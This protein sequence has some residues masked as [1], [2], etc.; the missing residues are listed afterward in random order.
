MG[1]S[2]YRYDKIGLLVEARRGASF[3]EAF[4]YDAAGALVGALEGLDARGNE[5]ATWDVLPGNLLARTT[6]AKYTYDKRG[7]RVVKLDLR[8]GKPGDE[9]KATEYVWDSRDQLREVKLP[10][11]AR[12]VMTY[13][14]LGRRVRK[15]VVSREGVPERAVDFLWDGDSIA[16][17]IDATRGAR[18]FVHAPGTLLPLLQAERGEVL[19]YV[20][21]HLGTPRELIDPAGK[22]AWS[23]AHS[24]WGRVA[25]THADP[26]S[27]LG[28]KRKVDSPFRLI[29][30]YADE[31]T[32]LSHTRYRYFDPEVGRWC[33]PDPLGI[34]GEETSSPSTGA[35]PPG[36]IRSGSPG[37]RTPHPTA[38]TGPREQGTTP[39]PTKGGTPNSVYT[40]R[41]QD[42]ESEA[43]RRLR[44]EWRRRGPRR[45]QEPRQR[46]ERSHE[47]GCLRSRPH[48]LHAGRSLVRARQGKVHYD[49]GTLPP[50]YSA[51][52][53]GVQPQTPIGQ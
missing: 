7:R 27:E 46:P 50:S 40:R 14:A 34:A 19:T 25:D 24:A 2:T 12:V 42:R 30:Q 1:T 15:E 11:G 29:G 51:L 37:A 4:T 48:V 18:C 52:P 44:S 39:P 13:D 20:N 41:S 6:T 38:G 31:E 22:I 8:P 47:T 21:D 10:G 49:P 9:P 23:A 16:A 33:S 3:R 35:P 53:P 28:R 5:G 45:L 43:E 32:G 17:D 36:W 26:T